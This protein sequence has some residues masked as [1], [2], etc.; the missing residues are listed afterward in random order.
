MRGRF[1]FCALGV[2]SMVSFVAQADTG[3]ASRSVELTYTATITELPASAKVVDLWL[4]V[5]QDTDGQRVS[6][7]NVTYPE[8]GDVGE[9]ADYGNRI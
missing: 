9:D 5:A 1:L 3:P 8:G 2:V 6:A 7:F 4:P